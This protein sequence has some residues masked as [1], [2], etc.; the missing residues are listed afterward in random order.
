MTDGAK[1][2]EW[3]E[4]NKKRGRQV[5]D[6]ISQIVNKNI[7]LISDRFY[8]TNLSEKI[9][10]RDFMVIININLFGL[11][12]LTLLDDASMSTGPLTQL[13]IDHQLDLL[14]KSI[15]GQGDV[16]LDNYNQ[17]KRSYLNEKLI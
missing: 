10:I 17:A 2:T 14:I 7:D 11:I 8:Y 16:M 15:E 1:I 12:V 3:Y 4:E 5:V 9:P 6:I 13:I